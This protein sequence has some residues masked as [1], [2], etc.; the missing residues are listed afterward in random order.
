MQI[1]QL[2]FEYPRTGFSL[3]IPDLTVA[4]GERVAVVGP[5]GSG[6]TTLLHLIS[7]ILVPQQGSIRIGEDRL[8]CL[9]ESQRRQL[10]LR[11]LGLIFQNFELIE[12]LSVLDNVLLTCR[13]GAGRVT[14]QV[15]QRSVQLLNEVGLAHLAHRSVTRL[16]QGERQ[17]VA[18][19]RALLHSPGLLLADEPTGNLDPTTSHRILQLL[20]D[21]TRQHQSTLLMVTHDHSLLHHFD[22]T[23]D[24]AQFLSAPA[25]V[26]GG[27]S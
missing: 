6:K 19:C 20:L 15:S 24:F 16:S 14:A 9:P 2:K 22:R 25:T 18:I 3:Q 23:I 13:I 17:R 10:R 1:T 21:S 27:A 11:K 12:Y 5:S 4:D 7:G 26:N 8:E